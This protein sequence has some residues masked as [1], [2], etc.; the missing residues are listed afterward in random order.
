MT[1]L[2]PVGRLVNPFIHALQTQRQ[3][4]DPYYSILG[5]EMPLRD[6]REASRGRTCPKIA[7]ATVFLSFANCITGSSPHLSQNMALKYSAQLL[8]TP[9]IQ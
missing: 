4:A 5:D 8:C 1:E 6:L 3:E 9:E 2:S 7:Q